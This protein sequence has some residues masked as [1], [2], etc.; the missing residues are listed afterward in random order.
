M[1]SPR[2]DQ[3]RWVALLDGMR[4]EGPPVHRDAASRINRQPA[5]EGASRR[6]DAREA[7]TSRDRDADDESS[8]RL[9]S[10]D[11]R[12]PAQDT[13]VARY[14]AASEWG[15]DERRDGDRVDEPSDLLA[16]EAPC[17]GAATAHSTSA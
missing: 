16:R 10:D 13:A 8:D 12:Q 4:T 1:R 15:L 17:A 2:R 6:T 11:R 5:T 14:S 9:C 7:L 3:R